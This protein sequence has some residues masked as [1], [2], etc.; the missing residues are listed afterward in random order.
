VGAGR[1]IVRSTGLRARSPLQ[2]K[3]EYADN[4]ARPKQT[5]VI[6]SRAEKFGHVRDH[7]A[8]ACKLVQAL[9]RRVSDHLAVKILPPGDRS[10]HTNYA[11]EDEPGTHPSRLVASHLGYLG[12]VS[13][14]ADP[15]REK[16][17]A[18]SQT[19]TAG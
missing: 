7:S 2:E 3:A 1:I 14:I 12:L 18:Y 8:G 4:A 17:A 5:G 16:W 6:T 10:N 13:S 19:W 9:D 15:V 11:E